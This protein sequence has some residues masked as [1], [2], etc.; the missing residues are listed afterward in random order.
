MTCES[1]ERDLD[2]YVDG[3]LGADAEA[4]IRTHVDGCAACRTRVEKRRAMIRLVQ[5]LP[6]YDAPANVR[7]RVAQQAVQA[8]S[9][10]QYLAM[11]A[12]AIVVLAAGAGAA[13]LSMAVAGTRAGV[14]TVVDS[15]VR[16][17]MADHLFDVRSTDQH[18]VKPWFTGKL[19][20]SPPVTD[21]ASIGYPLIGGRV[22]YLDGRAV[23]ALVYQRRQHVI[24]VF[25]APD[26]GGSIWREARSLRGF[27]VRH[28]TARGMSFW[29]VSDLNDTELAEFERALRLT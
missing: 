20:F 8:R 14:D 26:T 7:G 18:T 2:A 15:H 10:R 28:W 4:A 9:V 19:D 5:A 3:E 17:L 21:L 24:N 1:V 6:Y 29:A 22:D 12:A 16:S 23:A 11:A 25:V 27:Q 13:R